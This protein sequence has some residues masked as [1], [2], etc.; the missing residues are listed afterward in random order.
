MKERLGRLKKEIVP[1]LRKRGVIKAGIF[2]SY[3][4]G[5]QTRKSDMDI[6]IKFRGR[7][8]LLDIVKL[9]HEIENKVKKKVDL[10]T[11][12]SI[13]PLLKKDILKDEIR[14]IHEKRH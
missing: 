4:R 14:I 3:A 9:K 8:S 13:H 5:E 11:Y 6:L 10:L 7:K 1:L 2:G 12:R